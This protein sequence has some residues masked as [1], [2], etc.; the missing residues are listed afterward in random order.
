MHFPVVSQDMSTAVVEFQGMEECS[1]PFPDVSPSTMQ[2]DIYPPPS[3]T[4]SDSLQLLVICR[5]WGWRTLIGGHYQASSWSLMALQCSDRWLI[6]NLPLPPILQLLLSFLCKKRWNLRS[7]SQIKMV[8]DVLGWP[9]RL[10]WVS[11]F[12]VVMS[13][14]KHST[15]VCQLLSSLNAMIASAQILSPKTVSILQANYN[16]FILQDCSPVCIPL[17]CRRFLLPLS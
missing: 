13:I 5:S 17:L 15:R 16:D 4:I 1:P 6:Q 9:F 3:G 2:R 12:F 11:R 8:I 10:P 14:S 7:E